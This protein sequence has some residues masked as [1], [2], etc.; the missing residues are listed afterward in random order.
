[1][2]KMPFD[3]VI[4]ILNNVNSLLSFKMQTPYISLLKATYSAKCNLTHGYMHLK[5]CDKVLCAYV[6]CMIK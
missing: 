2:N 3:I 5:Y 1:M 6:L 4:E